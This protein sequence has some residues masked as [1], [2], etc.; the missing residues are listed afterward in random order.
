M[1]N[2]EIVVIISPFSKSLDPDNCCLWWY[3]ID[4]HSFGRCFS[5]RK[6][7]NINIFYQYVRAFSVMLYQ[8]SCRN[9][10]KMCKACKEPCKGVSHHNLNFPVAYLKVIFI[11]DIHSLQRTTD[12]LMSPHQKYDSKTTCGKK[13]NSLKL[14]KHRTVELLRAHVHRKANRSHLWFN[15]CN[16]TTRNT[17]NLCPGK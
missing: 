10:T 16:S 3:A 5:P 7:I 15:K 17:G 6:A 14:F 8:L 4:I 9:I 11:V 1:A 2:L 13:T 12:T